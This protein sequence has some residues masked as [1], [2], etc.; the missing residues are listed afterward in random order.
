[1]P[2]FTTKEKVT[3]KDIV[4]EHIK[5]ISLKALSEFKG[6]YWKKEVKGN[7]VEEVYI[8]DSRK[9]YIQG[10]EFL[11]DLLL[12][13]F[14]KKMNDKNKEIKEAVNTLLKNLEDKEKK[15]DSND[16]VIGKLRLMR[17]LFQQLMIFLKRSKFFKKKIIVG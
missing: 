16:Y 6:G 15:F 7:F 12:P 4:L 3:I 10:I 2:P 17:K 14:D 1:M 13:D 11:S 9:E 5:A 8:P